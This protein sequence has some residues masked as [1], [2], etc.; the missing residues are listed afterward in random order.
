MLN[1]KI[2]IL[3]PEIVPL[4]NKGEEAIIKGIMDIFD[5]TPKNCFYQICARNINS[6]QIK[7]GLVVHPSNLFFS[8]WRT[9]EFGLG[10]SS[11]RITSSLYAIIRHLLYHVPGWI[12]RRP[13]NVRLLVKYI[14][15][16]KKGNISQ[17]P[18][19]Y[20]DSIEYIANTDYIIAGHNGGLNENVCHV[21]IALKELGYNYSIF[22]SCMK[23]SVKNKSLI[24]LYDKMFSQADTIIS[25][26]PV[27]FRWYKKY[28]KYQA[29]LAP[30]PA[31]YMQPINS[32]ETDLLINKL[33][34]R[35]FFEKKVI[36]VTT[37]EPAP[38]SQ[39]SFDEKK[40]RLEKIKAHRLFLS[41]IIKQLLKQTDCNILF[42]PHTIGPEKYLDD[43]I[44]SKN[45]LELADLENNINGR[46]F[47][48]ED[49][50]S[51]REL[52]G[53]ISRAHILLA[54]RVHSIIGA[55]GVQTPFICLASNKD[56]RVNGMLKEF[57]GLED[58]IFLLNEPD[59]SSFMD[60]FHKCIKNRD[61]IIKQ[62]YS[63]DKSNKKEL[64]KISNQIVIPK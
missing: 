56:N 6:T 54:E 44:I 2:T 20:R 10:F 28:F 38:I 18:T 15:L 31:F 29:F 41:K 47:V 17:I 50:L 26:N 49:D 52:K 63:L 32:I 25:R 55:I 13:K 5:Y 7:R 24:K 4:E 62:L 37:A 16:Y 23:P 3:C 22:G 64:I 12:Q 58:F 59:V 46:C 61:D 51:G 60:L 53:L 21:L 19:L 1:N 34:L 43:R 8:R 33:S 39:K 14:L 48:L 45:V 9:S 11:E 27:G 30:D 35:H 42:L 40:S 36:M 57:A